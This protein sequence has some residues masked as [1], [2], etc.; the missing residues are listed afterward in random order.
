MTHPEG[1]GATFLRLS[2][3]FEPGSFFPQHQDTFKEI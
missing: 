1:H 3:T 2:K